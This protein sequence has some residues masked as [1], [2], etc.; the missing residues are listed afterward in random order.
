MKRIFVV[1]TIAAT[2]SLIYGCS[3]DATTATGS[4]DSGTPDSSTVTDSAT[5]T[6]SSS[7]TDGATDAGTDTNQPKACADTP[8][9][10]TNPACGVV[11]QC[12]T[13]VT[14]ASDATDL[15]AGT[16]TTLP[17]GTWVLTAVKA[18]KVAIPAIEIKLTAR[19]A[20]STYQRIQSVN[21][22]G[23]PDAVDERVSGTYT[24]TGGTIQVTEDCPTA[25][26]DDPS[27]FTVSGSTV[28][29]YTPQSGGA[30]G[31]GVAQTFTV[32]P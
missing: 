15:P 4:P 23:S 18:H 11:G 32:I 9:A 5:A 10:G 30:A 6:D 8:D 13:F 7:S 14:M 24:V 26:A 19:F 21:I 22:G 29:V 1:T 27:T 12:G 2:I 16:S 28:T 3:D 17:T 31:S 25:D 20:A